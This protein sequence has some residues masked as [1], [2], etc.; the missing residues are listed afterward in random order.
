M[1]GFFKK[2]LITKNITKK[3][4]YLLDNAYLCCG[5]RNAPLYL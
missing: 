1:Q 4:G 5:K 3:F 2:K